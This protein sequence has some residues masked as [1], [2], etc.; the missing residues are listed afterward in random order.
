[1]IHT[2]N[3]NSC[4]NNISNN[5][6]DSSIGFRGPQHPPSVWDVMREFYIGDLVEEKDTKQS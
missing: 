4:I 6:G 1:M 3:N 2:D 5:V